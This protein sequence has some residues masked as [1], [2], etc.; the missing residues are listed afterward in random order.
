MTVIFFRRLFVGFP[1]LNQFKIQLIF[2]FQNVFPLVFIVS[3]L[4]WDLNGTY[5]QSYESVQPFFVLITDLIDNFWELLVSSNSFDFIVEYR[6]N[7][8]F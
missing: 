2:Q 8:D 5:K 1:T 3:F 4:W 6:E 7:E